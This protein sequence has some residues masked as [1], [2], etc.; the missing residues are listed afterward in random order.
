MYT[1]VVLS[2]VL[3]LKNLTEESKTLFEG[4][5]SRMFCIRIQVWY[6]T[7]VRCY[8]L[9]DPC[10]KYTGPDRKSKSYSLTPAVFLPMCNA[11][12]SGFH[13]RTFAQILTIGQ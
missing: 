6:F 5:G 1:S 13:K 9:Q 10:T 3:F 11:H 4:T 2:E 8:F 7:S 12:S